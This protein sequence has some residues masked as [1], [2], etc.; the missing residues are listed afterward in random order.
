MKTDQRLKIKKIKNIDLFLK[1][2]LTLLRT[3]Q[4]LGFGDFD[5]ARGLER[6]SLHTA[7]TAP[8]N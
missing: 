2:T 6:T 8:D 1:L 5:F 7:A 3:L 4:K